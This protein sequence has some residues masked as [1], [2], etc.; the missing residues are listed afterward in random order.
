MSRRSNNTNK[1]I[2]TRPEVDP[3]TTGFI[4]SIMTTRNL[5]ADLVANERL[6]DLEKRYMIESYT[7]PD[8]AEKLDLNPVA[9]KKT[10][11]ILDII[12][13]YLRS[14]SSELITTASY[15]SDSSVG[16]FFRMIKSIS[17]QAD[18]LIE[19][20]QKMS[21]DKEL[22][23]SASMD[24]LKSV[25]TEYQ[26]ILETVKDNVEQRMMI[27]HNYP[28]Q[29][30]QYVEVTFGKL[31]KISEDI[32]NLYDSYLTNVINE[33]QQAQQNRKVSYIQNGTNHGDLRSESDSDDDYDHESESDSSLQQFPRSNW[34]QTRT[35]NTNN[36]G[37]TYSTNNSAF[38]PVQTNIGTLHDPMMFNELT[39]IRQPTNNNNKNIL[40]Q[41]Q[42]EFNRENTIL[43]KLNYE[44]D[45]LE[46]AKQL[47]SDPN[48]IEEL[49]VAQRLLISKL[50]VQ[51]VKVREL[52]EELLI[53]ESRI[54]NEE[55]LNQEAREIHNN[56]LNQEPL[57]TK[58][59]L[60]PGYLSDIQNLKTRLKKSYDKLE[61]LISEFIVA[62][63]ERNHDR[64]EVLK[65]DFN[66]EQNT[67]KK[68]I[69]RY[70]LLSNN[71]YEI[72]I[73]TLPPDTLSP[74][75]RS[76]SSSRSLSPDTR[77]RASSEAFEIP[78]DNDEIF[79]TLQRMHN[80]N[81]DDNSNHTD[82][83]DN[84]DINDIEDVIEAVADSRGMI[85]NDEIDIINDIK[86]SQVA[87]SRLIKYLGI[88]SDLSNYDKNINIINKYIE[89][90]LNDRTEKDEQRHNGDFKTYYVNEYTIL[91]IEG[92]CCDTR[93]DSKSVFFIKEKLTPVELIER[94]NS[95]PIACKI[96][97]A[98][99]Y[100]LNWLF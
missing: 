25:A 86:K 84:N 3:K 54:Q 75:T 63:H 18:Q 22:L 30:K 35:N 87:L 16:E 41:A 61:Y 47:S 72:E 50:Y 55:L 67:F 5:D 42:N 96:I 83:V 56:Q 51:D 77:S 90:R 48:E 9:V 17:L 15:L 95:I 1:Y 26:D 2:R 88:E 32:E 20:I 98:I 85:D 31:D 81:D 7:N 46:T 13:K 71:N 52:E 12:I 39:N 99:P 8:L 37:S 33:T 14:I 44:I 4:G 74:D 28:D 53:L 79:N 38:A 69:E 93:P 36:Q 65:L 92:S 60:D 10:I 66:L 34:N 89:H 76:R 59:N 57:P 82:N 19:Q 97:K 68:L 94:I 23:P 43:K 80:I 91:A 27:L 62:Q 64:K 78:T 11:K 6:Y 70:K 73:P 45:K 21:T 40:D 29:I 58:H 49:D 100:K 24:L